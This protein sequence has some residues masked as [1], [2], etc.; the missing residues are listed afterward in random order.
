MTRKF[1]KI[2]DFTHKK[3][4]LYIY[5]F[6]RKI[7]YL[8]GKE[9]NHMKKL[10]TKLTAVILI[11]VVVGMAALFLVT[12]KK[13]TQMAQ[14]DAEQLL[15]EAV[16]QR[17]SLIN[18][19]NTSIKNAVVGFSQNE[20]LGMYLKE[21]NGE[22]EPIA[23]DYTFKSGEAYVQHYK[24][25]VFPDRFEGLFLGDL[26][27][28]TLLHSNPDTIGTLMREEGEARD[29]LIASLDAVK[30]EGET[31]FAGARVSPNS[32]Q[33]VI[34]NYVPIR[35]EN[36]K[37]IGFCGGGAI[38]QP[39]LDMFDAQPVKGME[40][41][42]YYLVDVNTGQYLF[43]SEDPSLIGAAVADN[44]PEDCKRDI[45]GRYHSI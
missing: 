27:T 9:V 13:V 11:V 43:N 44:D 40:N 39:L 4:V 34:V 38:T 26:N 28:D 6:F 1:V 15:S 29:Q 21:K 36:G 22:A 20:L 18:E 45:T 24:E 2:I 33:V 17:V 7:K 8:K 19:Y 3:V 31:F 10:S 5:S 37:L 14:T 41:A 32:G 30:E 16:E 12:E 35:N 23:G 25:C 42:N